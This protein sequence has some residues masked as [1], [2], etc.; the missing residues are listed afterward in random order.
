[1]ADCIFCKIARKEA[2]ATF[3]YEDENFVA[4]LDIR[5]KAPTHVLLIPKAHVESLN[6]VGEEDAE[7]LGKFALAARR[8]ALQKGLKG[9]TIQMHVGREG[10]QEVDHI[11]IHLLSQQKTL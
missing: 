6:D 4:F 5:P 10:G 1:M 11:H 7:F 9:Y 3:A 2:P 8:V